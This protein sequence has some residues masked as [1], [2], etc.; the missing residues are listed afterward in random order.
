M[1]VTS[2]GQ[3]KVPYARSI[4]TARGTHVGTLVHEVIQWRAE[5]TNEESVFDYSP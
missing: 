5:Q 2:V 4:A 3:F 1:R